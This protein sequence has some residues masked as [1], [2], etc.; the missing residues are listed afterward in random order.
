VADPS[1][2]VSLGAD[3]PFCLRG[4]RAVVR[5][6]GEVLEPLTP[7]ALSFVVVT[8]A[9]GVS[10]VA[11]YRAYDELGAGDG[12]NDLERAAIAVEP[13]LARVRDL[14]AGVAK[15]RPVL[16][17]SGSSFFVE[18]TVDRAGPLRNEIAAASRAE[19]IVAS[20]VECA[21]TG[22]C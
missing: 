19:G 12:V 13:R 1:V 2:A 15:E 14:I 16:A 8:P 5:G 6:I 9:F 21:S 11:A 22:L 17:G 18:C 4:G 3:V 10:T 7:L 20:V